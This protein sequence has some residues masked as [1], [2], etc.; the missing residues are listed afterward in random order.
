VYVLFV[1]CKLFITIAARHRAVCKYSRHYL[2]RRQQVVAVTTNMAN[3]YKSYLK[4]LIIA[5]KGLSE[6]PGGSSVNGVNHVSEKENLFATHVYLTSI[7]PET[8]R[9]SA[10]KAS[11]T[12]QSLCSRI[13]RC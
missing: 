9:Y 8:L 10:N 2:P 4:S 7:I 5:E 12:E 13:Y 6:Q 3:C 1:F 11:N